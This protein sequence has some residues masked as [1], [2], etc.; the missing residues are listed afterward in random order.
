[1]Y[2]F[3]ES[4]LQLRFVWILLAF[5]ILIRFNVDISC[6]CNIPGGNASLP[7]WNRNAWIKNLKQ[8]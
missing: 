5:L 3:I 4:A 8:N 6:I 7:N 2:M 1:M